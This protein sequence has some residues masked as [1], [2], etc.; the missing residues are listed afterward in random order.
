MIT[1]IVDSP[2]QDFYKRIVY[3]SASGAYEFRRSFLKFNAGQYGT[4]K[5][6]PEDIVIY[7]SGPGWGDG[8]EVWVKQLK[9]V[10]QCNHSQT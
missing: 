1:I 7:Y 2:P 4:H 6:E 10:T 3:D 8:W 9:E 5:V